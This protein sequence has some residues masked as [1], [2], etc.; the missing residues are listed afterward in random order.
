MSRCNS[1]GA[2]MDFKAGDEVIVCVTTWSSGCNDAA[3]T[4]A[5]RG[6]VK[7]HYRHIN[8]L[9]LK[10]GTLLNLNDCC[11]SVSKPSRVA[12]FHREAP[13]EEE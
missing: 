11:I 7:K 8:R 4:V 2:E 5:Q 6:W 3:S 12:A 9:L 1:C 10:N 13:E